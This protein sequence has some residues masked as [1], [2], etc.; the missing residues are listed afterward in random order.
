MPN[1]GTACLARSITSLQV[2]LNIERLLGFIFIMLAPLVG[3]RWLLVVLVGLAQHQDVFT[4]SE[5]VRVDLDRVEVGVGV[6]ALRL[7][8]GAPVIVPDGKIFHTLRSGVQGLG[9]VPD[10]LPSPVNPDVAGLYPGEY[11][12][13]NLTQAR[14][15]PPSLTNLPFCSSCRNLDKTVLLVPAF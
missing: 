13:R 10:T 14:L 11:L 4:A 6:G 2:F 1:Q 12:V 15:H 7:V 5:G 9:L 3:L 8:A